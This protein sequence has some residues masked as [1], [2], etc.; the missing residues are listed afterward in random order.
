[1]SERE[2]ISRREFLKDAGLIFGGAA[3]GSISLMSACNNDEKTAAQTTCSN[4]PAATVIASAGTASVELTVNGFTSAVQVE[5]NMSLAEVLRDK[6]NLTGTKVGCDRGTC[7][8]CTVLA[9][10]KPVLSCMMLAIECGGINITTIEGLANG[11]TLH[12][13]QQAVYEHTG[14]QCGFCT[15]GVIMEAKALLDE[16]PNPT[17]EEIKAALGGHICRCGSFYS[18]IESVQLAGGK[19]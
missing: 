15:P 10:G 7:G 6:L 12:P 13:L 3:V 2:Q 1:M 4:T 9:N 18:F 16:N 19:K 8:A 11:A 5:P 17:V 14:Y